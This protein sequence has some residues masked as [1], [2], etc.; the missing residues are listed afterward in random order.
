MAIL[1]LMM[2]LNSMTECTEMNSPAVWRAEMP[3]MQCNDKIPT[4]VRTIDENNLNPV[5]GFYMIT[6]RPQEPGA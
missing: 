4:L 3:K 2:C 1:V 6:C 5:N